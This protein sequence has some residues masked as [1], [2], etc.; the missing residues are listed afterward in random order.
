M[1][2]RGYYTGRMGAYETVWSDKKKTTNLKDS[3]RIY[4][5]WCI[6]FSWILPGFIHHYQALYE[7]PTAGGH[8]QGTRGFS[9][10]FIFELSVRYRPPISL[11]FV[12]D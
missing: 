10:L 7:T 2:V 1:K 9:N 11:T 3:E 6:Y 4:A 5:L 8:V 12:I